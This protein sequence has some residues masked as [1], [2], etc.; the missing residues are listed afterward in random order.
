MSDGDLLD[1]VVAR[2]WTVRAARG[3]HL[4]RRWVGRSARSR[5]LFSTW[6]NVEPDF[7]KKKTA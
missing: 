2:L 1:D 3:R 7:T 6:P 4:P 5:V